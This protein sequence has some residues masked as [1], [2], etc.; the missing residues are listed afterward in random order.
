MD[1]GYGA[2]SHISLQFQVLEGLTVQF[3]T[4]NP[5]R[6]SEDKAIIRRDDW[7]AMSR[8]QLDGLRKRAP[9]VMKG[10]IDHTGKCTKHSKAKLA[11]IDEGLVLAEFHDAVLESEK[12]K[13]Y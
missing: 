4:V 9:K 7:E 8:L 13:M 3:Q 5:R 10:Q 12:K 1:L 6:D 11:Q 2:L